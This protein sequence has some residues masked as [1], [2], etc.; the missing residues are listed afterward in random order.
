VGFCTLGLAALALRDAMAEA[1]NTILL[2][3]HLPDLK[4]GENKLV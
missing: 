4:K 1:S 3:T 2:E